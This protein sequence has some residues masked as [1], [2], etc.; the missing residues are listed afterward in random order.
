MA[1]ELPPLFFE[2][3]CDLMDIIY[4]IDPRQ[5]S[6]FQ[7]G[8]NT[9]RQFNSQL[10]V[11]RKPRQTP[12]TPSQEI[13]MVTRASG[14]QSTK[15]VPKQGQNKPVPGGKAGAGDARGTA[16]LPTISRT[17]TRK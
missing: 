2:V 7:Q 9:F 3:M 1:E 8:T 5:N 11:G 4:P 16:K 17:T 10:R 14:S 13:S 12:T 6:Y 15:T